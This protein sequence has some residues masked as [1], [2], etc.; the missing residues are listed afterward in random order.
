MFR[1]NS[2]AGLCFG[3]DFDGTCV[4]HKYPL[5][6]TPV[7]HCINVLKRIQKE[8]GLLILWT[9]RSDGYLQDAVKYLTDNGITLY[10]I[11]TNPRQHTWTNSPKAE[12]QIYIDDAALGCPLIYPGEGQRPYVDWKKVEELLF[13]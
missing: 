3:I 11:N 5:V 10:G 13:A 4:L 1:Y 12:A 7:P 2:V 8:G 6:G 9:M